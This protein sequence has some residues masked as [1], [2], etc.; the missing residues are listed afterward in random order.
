MA[1]AYAFISIMY[2]GGWQL[3]FD[4]ALLGLEYGDFLLSLLQFGA[5]ATK[6]GFWIIFF[7]WVRWSIPRFRY[8]QLMNLGWKIMLPIAIVNVLVTAICIAIFDM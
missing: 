3:P 6:V 7:I 8:D 2:F 5:F 4:H 1:T